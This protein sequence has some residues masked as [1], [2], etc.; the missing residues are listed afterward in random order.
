MIRRG[1]GRI[2]AEHIHGVDR[3][4]DALHVSPS[5]WSP[6]IDPQQDVAVR[7]HE[8]QGLER[9]AATDGAHDVNARDDRAV[10]A[11][12]PS[13]ESEDAVGREVD[14]AATAVDDPFVALAAEPDPMLT[15]CFWKVRSTSVVNGAGSFGCGRP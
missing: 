12:H 9:L 10:F 5:H 13:D 6:A 11:R 7:T 14:D 4:K 1:V 2:D 15:F 3:R 8:R